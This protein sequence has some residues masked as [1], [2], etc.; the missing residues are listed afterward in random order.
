M[1]SKLTIDLDD[2]NQPI[3][4]IDYVYSEDVRDKIVKRF[5]ESFGSESCY[6]RFGYLNWAT[7][8]S[9]YGGLSR[10]CKIRPIKE[11]EL[12]AEQNFL[13]LSVDNYNSNFKKTEVEVE[14]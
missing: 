4:L 7:D 8:S 1:K 12:E 11:T 2:D 14:N 13:K 5:I 6:A 3:I 9:P 10:A